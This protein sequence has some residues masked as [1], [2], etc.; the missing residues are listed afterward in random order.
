MYHLKSGSKGREGESPGDYESLA[1]GRGK[2]RGPN[3]KSSDDS[4][5]TGASTTAKKAPVNPG[6]LVGQKVTFTRRKKRKNSS[7]ERG[8]KRQGFLLFT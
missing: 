5:G 6:G 8:K 4:R 2:R 3:K 1:V 7:A